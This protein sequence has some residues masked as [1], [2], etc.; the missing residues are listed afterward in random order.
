MTTTTIVDQV[1]AEHVF[2]ANRV[3]HEKLRDCMNDIFSAREQ[4]ADPGDLWDEFEARV[5]DCATSLVGVLKMGRVRAGDH[6]FTAD[7]EMKVA[8]VTGQG[9]VPAT[10][11]LVSYGDGLVTFEVPGERAYI[12]DVEQVVLTADGGQAIME[13]HSGPVSDKESVRYERYDGVG[14]RLGHGYVDPC[15]RKIVQTG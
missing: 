8:V 3:A 1:L 10:T 15:T 5:Q 13:W 12:R 14:R 7:G 11:K 9:Y 4:N 2:T 6:V